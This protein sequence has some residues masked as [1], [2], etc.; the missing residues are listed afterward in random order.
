ML[1]I[2]QKIGVAAEAESRYRNYAAR[3][4]LSE[5]VMKIEKKKKIAQNPKVVD[6]II[7]K[8]PWPG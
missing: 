5:E 3:S 6:L 1:K 4:P 7:I 8:R 2:P